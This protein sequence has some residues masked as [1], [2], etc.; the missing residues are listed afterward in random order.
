MVDARPDGRFK[1]TAPEP[2]PA[3]PSG[4]FANAINVPFFQLFDREKNVMK[5]SDGVLETFKKHGVDL[6][7]EMISSCGSGVA[8]SVVAFA[9]HFAKG[10][11][12]PL[13]DGSWAEWA[14]TVPELILKDA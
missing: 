12:I 1:G 14:T 13:Y 5:Q 4:H 6:D 7:K 9:L 10:T 11:D 3:I 8:A 2:N